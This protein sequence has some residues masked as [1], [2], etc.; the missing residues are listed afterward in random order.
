MIQSKLRRFEKVI[1]GVSRWLN[2]MASAAMVVMLVV[3]FVDVA[4]AKIFNRPLLGA[5]DV[6]SLS[7]LLIAAFAIP[8][9]QVLGSHIKIEFFMERLGKRA[10]AVIDSIMSLFGLALFAAMTWQ[11][12]DFSQTLQVTKSVSQS[13]HIPLYPFTYAVVIA[14]FMVCPLLLVQFFRAVTEVTKK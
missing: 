14:F 1:N 13:S 7:G 10:Q 4:G 3:V 12:F 11:M 8:F 9:T 5:D 6:A 2:W